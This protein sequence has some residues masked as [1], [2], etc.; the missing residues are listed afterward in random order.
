MRV[1]FVRGAAQSRICGPSPG[2]V[3]GQPAHPLTVE[4]LATRCCSPRV[5]ADE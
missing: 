1:D 3:T 2:L 5:A 4:W